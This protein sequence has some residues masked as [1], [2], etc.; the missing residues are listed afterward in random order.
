MSFNLLKQQDLNDCGISCCAMLVNHFLNTNFSL[1]EFKYQ[2][3]YNRQ[4]LSFYEIETILNGYQIDCESYHITDFSELMNLKGPILVDIK[5]DDGD[6]HYL[7]LEKYHDNKF[8]AIDPRKESKKEIVF[9]KLV[10][11]LNGN[12]MLFKLQKYQKQFRSEQIKLRKQFLLKIAKE[13]LAIYLGLSFL[14]FL[15]LTFFLFSN[16]FLKILISNYQFLDLNHLIKVLGIFFFF[17][18]GWVCLSLL[19]YQ[20]KYRFISSLVAKELRKL[21]RKSPVIIQYLENTNEEQAYK[22]LLKT[23]DYLKVSQDLIIDF[24]SL[25][26]FSILVSFMTIKYSLILFF[27]SCLLIVIIVIFKYFKIK[28]LMRINNQNLFLNYQQQKVMRKIIFDYPK[29]MNKTSLNNYLLAKE[30]LIMIKPNQQIVSVVFLGL[31]KILTYCYYALMFLLLNFNEFDISTFLI[32]SNIALIYSSQLERYL[33]NI[34]RIRREKPYMLNFN[35]LETKTFNSKD[36]ITFKNNEV[37]TNEKTINFADLQYFLINYQ[38]LKQ[39]FLNNEIYLASNALINEETIVNNLFNFGNPTSLKVFQTL[40]MQTL[41]DKY[42]IDLTKE[43]YLKNL[44]RDQSEVLQLL[45]CCFAKQEI[46]IIPKMHFKEFSEYKKRMIN[47]CDKR[48]FIF[49]KDE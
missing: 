17:I 12:L 35:N 49:L 1:E 34:L 13:N 14:S 33:E 31:E 44:S 28:K 25:F 30:K 19:M 18:I 11:K 3:K 48:L 2:N 40:E 6:Y 46:L 7:I 45:S 27:A 23:I 37:L 15:S 26:F 29:I 16:M 32:F 43:L 20:L 47:Y 42:Q 4:Q 5:L 36:M 9:D 38:S 21:D 39:Y 24:W 22:N 8:L 10:E 41:L